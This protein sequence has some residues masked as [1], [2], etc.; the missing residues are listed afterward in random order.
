MS[1][2]PTTVNELEP[3]IQAWLDGGP[4]RQLI[5]KNDPHYPARLKHL[6][7]APGFLFAHGHLDCLNA[8]SI[9]M[10]GSRNASANGLDNAHQWSAW[11]GS[12]GWCI[13]SGL[14]SGIDTAAHQGALAGHGKTIAVMGAGIDVIYPRRN[15]KLAQ[16]IIDQGGLL[17]SEYPPGVQPRPF[18]FPQRNRIIAGLCHGLVVVEAALQ[19]GS[20]ITAEFAA[21]QGRVVMAVPGS[22]HSSLAKGCHRMIRAGAILVD[23][24]AE[25]ESDCIP[26]LEPERKSWLKTAQT[27]CI[28]PDQGIQPDDLSSTQQQILTAMGFE[29]THLDVLSQR[30]HLTAEKLLAELSMM[31][32]GGLVASEPGQ[33]WSRLGQKRE[34][35][36]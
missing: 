19:S 35:V 25:I 13:V 11:L 3:V 30:T 33:Q 27:P 10:V 15:H 7:N 22:I 2:F 4:L 32:L 31:E 29:T 21:Q 23:K 12:R 16:T 9:G 36:Y 17:L 5:D 18:F 1:L 8:P 14:A 6:N 24:A 28:L 34:D 26:S 20:L